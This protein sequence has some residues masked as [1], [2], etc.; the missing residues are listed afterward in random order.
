MKKK[1]TL[2]TLALGLSTVSH[3]QIFKLNADV[4]ALPPALQSAALEAIQKIENDLNKDLPSAP[5]K[6]LM[7]GMADSSAI[8]GKGIGSDYA[9]GMQVL[10]VGVGAG[11]GADLEKDKTTDSD[12]SGVGVQPAL[13]IGANLGFLDAQKIL[14]LDT[15]K[16]NVYLSGMSYNLERKLGK[17]D[18]DEIS[19]KLTSLGVHFSYDWIKGNNSKLFGWGG[20]KIHTGYEYSSS[21]YR[22]TTRIN[23]TV[24]SDVGSGATI[25]GSLTGTPEASID[26]TTHS[27]P[28]EISSS[29]QFLYLFSLYGGLGA[30]FNMGEAKGSGAIN[31][32]QSTLTC[33]G[34][35]CNGTQTAT[36]APTANIDGKGKVTPFW[37]RAFLGVQI[38][39]P[40]TRIFVQADKPFGNEVVGATAGLR[41]VY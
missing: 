38:N 17:E 20:V 36:V 11:V 5:P 29:V 37:A 18:K 40:Y 1:L 21:K 31:A 35:P 41:F 26:V 16:L 23:E 30:D 9:S 28:I 12:L 14:G 19:A 22:F 7:E 33:N 13:V 3:A 10:M 15:S 39:L 27:I 34:G 4:S 2:L 8:S 32:Q 6:R 24:N 25:D